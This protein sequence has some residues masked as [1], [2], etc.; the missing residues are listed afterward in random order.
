MERSAA[1][2]HLSHCPTGMYITP[3][4]ESLLVW[5]GVFFVHKGYYASSVLRFA[6]TF[7]PNYPEK[8][9]IVNFATDVFHPLVSQQDGLFSLSPR[10]TPWR[11]REHHVFDVLYWIKSAF[12]KHA[13][14][15]LT[16]KDCLNKEA[17]RHRESVASFAALALQTSG[18]S[19]SPS[20]LYDRDH[21]HM[22]VPDALILC[23]T[24][25]AHSLNTLLQQSKSPSSSQP[26][27]SHELSAVHSDFVALLTLVYSHVTRV[28]ISFKPPISSDAAI[29]TV[30]DT[31]NEISRLTSCALAVPVPAGR[32]LR[33]EFI[34]AAQEVIESVQ[35][36]VTG[37][38]GNDAETDEYLRKVGSVHEVIE[39]TKTSLPATNRAAVE[40]LWNSN[41]ESLDDALRECQETVDQAV[42]K[43]G[44]D[45]DSGESDDF[46]WDDGEQARMSIEEIERANNI[47]PFLKLTTVLHRRLIKHYSSLVDLS[48]A[49]LDNKLMFSTNL[50]AGFD[51]LVSSL[52]PTQ[53][54]DAIKAEMHTIVDLVHSIKGEFD[55]ESVTRDLG[56]SALGEAPGSSG[57]TLT[58]RKWFQICFEQIDKAARNTG[59]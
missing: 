58:S 17:F 1:L 11:P 3:S 57:D 50:V 23:K 34:W 12:K 59:L 54:E 40:K 42:L 16:E 28:G 56:A 52:M 55:V 53:E 26:P 20:A 44:D 6:L 5:T 48:N 41:S 30:G 46:G 43:N 18:L 37:L 22:G 8:P 32:T 29:K 35:G 33:K 2:R 25:C 7:P 10:L 47:Y 49:E 4:P 24:V 38:L 27:G 21:P 45:S 15:Q 19:Q 31:S 39:K 36:L 13:L 14:D 9:P 51:D